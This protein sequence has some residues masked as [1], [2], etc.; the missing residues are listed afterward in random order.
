MAR[1][2]YPGKKISLTTKFALV[3]QLDIVCANGRFNMLGCLVPSFC[4]VVARMAKPQAPKERRPVFCLPLT[5]PPVPES[6]RSWPDIHEVS[7][8]KN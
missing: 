8:A 4:G 3:I 1:N 5:L 2:C 6:I 7:V